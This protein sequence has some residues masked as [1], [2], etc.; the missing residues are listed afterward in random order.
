MFNLEESI[1]QWRRQMLA[2]GVKAPM[3]L[4]EL[5]SHLRSNIAALIASGKS[6]AEAFALAVSRIGPPGPVRTEFDKIQRVSPWPLIIGSLLWIYA[7]LMLALHLHLMHLGPSIRAIA[8]KWEPLLATHIVCLTSGYMAA[9]IAGGVGIAYICCRMFQVLSPCRQQSLN[10]AAAVFSCLAVVLMV[11]GILFGTL[12]VNVISGWGPFG[13]NRDL[14][15]IGAWCAMAWMLGQIR[16]QRWN[17]ISEHTKMLVCIGGNIL[18]GLAWYGP[19][20]LYS[21]RQMHSS[22]LITHWVFLTFMAIHVC[23]LL[24][25]LAPATKPKLAE[26]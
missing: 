3:T 13:S 20:V 21:L 5:E 9:F 23:F 26:L 6:E 22:G 19:A 25:G 12:W 7:T 17:Q 18:V 14:Y 1:A 8:R 10:R 16:M 4:D 15:K 2:G 24:I 11:V